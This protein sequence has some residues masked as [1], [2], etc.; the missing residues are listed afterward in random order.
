MFWS[1][2]TRK[3][4]CTLSTTEAQNIALA[5]VIKEPLL[6]RQ[7]WRFMLPEVGMPAVCSDSFGG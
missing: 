1:S 2:R 7:V 4:D 3:R 5:D 6:I